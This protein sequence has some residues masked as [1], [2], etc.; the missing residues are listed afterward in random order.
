MSDNTDYNEYLA[1]YWNEQFGTEN[2]SGMVVLF[3]GVTATV[4]GATRVVLNKTTTSIKSFGYYDTYMKSLGIDCE[5][6]N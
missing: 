4:D 6:Y 1:K 2:P 3:T 5:A